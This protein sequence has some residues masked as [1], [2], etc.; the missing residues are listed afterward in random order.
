MQV[1]TLEKRWAGIVGIMVTVMLGSILYTALAYHAYPP[2]TVETVDST[3]LHL[4]EEFRE[5]NLG[6]KTRPD[7]S[8]LVTMVAHRYGFTP[9]N[10]EI[11]AGKPVTFRVATPD[12][13][14]G[15][16]IPGTNINTMVVP[17]YISVVNAVIDYDEVMK[18]GRPDDRG[19]VT[20]PLFCN[21]F[22][23]LNHHFMWSEVVILPDS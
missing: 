23:G 1:A 18:H 5:D 21:E 20:I 17:G 4:T 10:I 11:P 22:C 15:L 3:R 2:G 6:V 9:K 19:N 13:L 12:V 8:V 7:G 14:H 16:N